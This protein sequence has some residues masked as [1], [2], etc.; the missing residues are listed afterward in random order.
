MIRLSRVL[1]QGLRLNAIFFAAFV[2]LSGGEGEVNPDL[3]YK[4][5]T[6]VL[7]NP[8]LSARTTLLGYEAFALLHSGVTRT[9]LWSAEHLTEES[10]R[11]ARVLKR[12]NTF[13]KEPAL[14]PEDRS[15]LKDYERSGFDRGHLAPSG[16]MPT[17]SAQRE[18]FT[19]ANMIPQ[20][21]DNNQHLWE[22]L[23]SSL[24]DL[25]LKSGE[26]FVITGPLFEGSELKQLNGRVLIPTF[27]Y[28]A[29]YDPAKRRGA[30]YLAS[31]A[32]GWY[33]EVL[34][35]S[36][37]ESRAGINLFPGVT[38]SV[39]KETLELPRP[40]RRTRARRSAPTSP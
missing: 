5:H 14:D 38:P 32:P 18:C 39:K 7:L 37:M 8:K 27:V 28:K 26:L 31:N 19:L 30:A 2:A 9:A 33:F 3:F 21:P 12:K 17:A 36:D 34:S 20:D 10:V 4:G 1:R 23:E 13:H 15:E 25:T 22:A 11:D 24:R 6:P 40:V 29:V 16:D 35:L